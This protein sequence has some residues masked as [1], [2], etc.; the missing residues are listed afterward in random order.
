MEVLRI[1]K[2]LQLFVVYRNT[3]EIISYKQMAF[4][5]VSLMMSRF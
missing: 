3:F 4:E 5:V 1:A 2:E